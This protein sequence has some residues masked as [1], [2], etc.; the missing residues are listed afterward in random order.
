MSVSV[1]SAG[2][3]VVD[4]ARTEPAL[5][6]TIASGL[7][8]GPVTRPSAVIPST[9]KPA[10]AIA[11]S[12]A[13]TVTA[14]TGSSSGPSHVP[15]ATT[16]PVAIDAAAVP[17]PIP[18]RAAT[19]GSG[20]AIRALKPPWL[21]PPPMSIAACASI[22]FPASSRAV[23]F[24]TITLDG[25]ASKAAEARSTGR[26]PMRRRLEAAVPERRGAPSVPS[27]VPS[28][29]SG[30][31]AIQAA[32][33]GRAGNARFTSTAAGSRFALEIVSVPITAES[34]TAAALIAM[35]ASRSATV[36]PWASACV[37]RNLQLPG[38][39]ATS[40][41]AASSSGS[42]RSREVMSP[43]SVVNSRAD[44]GQ[45]SLAEPVATM[46]VGPI[47]RSG[48]TFARLAIETS[49]HCSESRLAG[50]PSPS[51]SRPAASIQPRPTLARIRST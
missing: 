14:R 10:R 15:A 42:T 23:A 39:K 24:D 1:T 12:R 32:T 47:G 6:C 38:D 17:A 18:V 37:P 11:T 40:I 35:V 2:I 43:D 13:V 5:T 16:D 33:S 45:F 25:V 9:L 28:S 29:V 26:P 44:P 34:A 21:L 36:P 20:F 31:S 51:G 27:T 48:K 4:G 30:V 8:S 22:A 46:P 41:R 7:E 50:S 49:A 19:K 3:G